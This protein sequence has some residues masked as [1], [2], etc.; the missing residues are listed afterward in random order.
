L[1]GNDQ[2]LFEELK[3]KI[4]AMMQQSFPGINPMIS[5]WKGQEISDFQEEL[6]IKV[7]ANISEKW[8][9]THMKG[10]H[11]RLPRI[12]VLNFLSQYA[13]YANWDDFVF[14][15]REFPSQ[16]TGQ[17]KASNRYFIIIPVITLVALSAFY[18]IFKYLNTQEY[19]FSFYDADTRERITDGK[20]E[21]KLLIKGESPVTSI[22]D[23]SGCFFL[24]TDDSRISMVV[25]NPYYRRDTIV[26]ILR[27]FHRNEE[28]TLHVNDYALMLHYL[29]TMKV[30]DW[31]KRRKQLNNIIDDKA[32]IYQ[33][34]GRKS[35]LGI[36]LL[37]KN[38]FVDKVTMPSSSLK[39]IEILDTKFRNEKII[40]IRFRVKEKQ[41]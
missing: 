19:K 24:K 12:D 15:N 29:S 36:D 11:P 32:T 39:N 3:K 28:I 33:V 35:V 6:R 5:K 25:S 4:V 22:C 17:V 13:G 40:E 26:R 34:Y 7:N 37:N 30:D 31:E 8:F 18:G 16:V 9:Y 2:I 21:V 23:S 38:E 27:K 1:S 14:R 20:I 41:E 10:T